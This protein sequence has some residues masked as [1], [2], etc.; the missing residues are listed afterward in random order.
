MEFL[1]P[2][3]K[4]D[5]NAI[6]RILKLPEDEVAALIP[7]LLE[8]LQDAN[9]PIAEPMSEFLATTDK[10]VIPHIVAVLRSNDSIWKYWCIRLLVPKLKPET[11][12]MLSV[13]LMALANMPSAEDAR[14]DVHVAAAEAIALATNNSL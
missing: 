13:E 4:F 9:W 14:E 5:I 6:E 3:D 12:S 2:E 8:W 11:A 7:K 10:L 1:L